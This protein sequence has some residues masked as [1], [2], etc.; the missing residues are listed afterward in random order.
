MII[1]IIVLIVAA[2]E[3]VAFLLVVAF[4]QKGSCATNES[5]YRAYRTSPN[6]AQ[7]SI[8]IPYYT[9]NVKRSFIKRP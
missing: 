1:T 5:L 3:A 8:A 6:N 7:K 9:E 4:H 2:A